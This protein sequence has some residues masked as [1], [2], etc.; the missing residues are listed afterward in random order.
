MTPGVA[1]S[2][3]V[4]ALVATGRASK[5]SERVNVEPV[6][7][8]LHRSQ[9]HVSFAA[10]EAAEVG[11]VDTDR[12]CHLLLREVSLDPYATDVRSRRPLQFA[13]HRLNHRARWPAVYRL[14]SIIGSWTQCGL[15]DRGGGDG[16]GRP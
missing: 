15:Q 6:G 12:V 13:L 9:R 11:A 14:I 5:E 1:A 16:S 2:D 7:D 3:E 4:V 10:L 8:P